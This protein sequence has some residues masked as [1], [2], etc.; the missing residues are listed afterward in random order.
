MTA[1]PSGEASIPAPLEGT[2]VERTVTI[3]NQKGLHARAAAK[4]VELAGKYQAEVEVLKDETSVSAR[5]IMG[6][7]MLAA[8]PGVE[9]ELQGKGTEAQ[10]AVDALAQLVLAKFH[11]D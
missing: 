10:A 7:M 8:S 11:E 9:I 5:S 4:F 2:A 3:V 6:L 1:G